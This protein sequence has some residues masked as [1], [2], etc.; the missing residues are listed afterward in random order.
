MG[1]SLDLCALAHR[2]AAVILN[3]AP[4]RSR[5]VQEAVEAVAKLGGDVFCPIIRERVALRHS[6]QTRTHATRETV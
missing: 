6:I 5:V 4:T 1:A 3:A 2:P